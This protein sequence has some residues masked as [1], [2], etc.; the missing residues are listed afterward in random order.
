MTQHIHR[1]NASIAPAVDEEKPARLRKREQPSAAFLARP[2][3]AP[4]KSNAWTWDRGEKDTVDTRIAYMHRT[5]EKQRYRDA[6]SLP[7]T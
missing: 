1:K 2:Q 7:V 5:V 4:T 6:T 3:K